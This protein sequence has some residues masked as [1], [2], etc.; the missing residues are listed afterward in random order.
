MMHY[1]IG[2]R[3]SAADLAVHNAKV[4]AG[5]GADAIVTPCTSCAVMLKEHYRDLV[6][7]AKLPEVLSFSQL[8]E[9]ELDGKI[10]PSPRKEGAAALA[11]HEPCHL[12]VALHLKAQPRA[13]LGSLRGATY[14]K[15][16]GEDA[17]CG[18]G[19][20]FNVEHYKASR[21]IGSKKKRAYEDRGVTIVATECAGCMLQL[22]DVLAD[23]EGPIEVISTAEA[24]DRYY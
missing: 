5:Y 17:C 15:T 22:T 3:R 16:A 2:D 7:D 4:L 9:R 12:G 10:A 24:L 21:R 14:M 23:C 6:P 18:Y 20:A 19:G 13:M 8:W 11:F 1:M